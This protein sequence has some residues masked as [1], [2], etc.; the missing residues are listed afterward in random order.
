MP[1]NPIERDLLIVGGGGAAALAALYAAAA[2]VNVTILS[3][4]GFIGG[5]TVQA[6][7]AF[8]LTVDALDSPDIFFQDM[9][10]TGE[11]I[12]NQRLV[13]ALTQNVRRDFL[14]L[15]KWLVRLDRSETYEVRCVKKNG[16]PFLHSLLC[17]QT[18][19]AWYTVCSFIIRESDGR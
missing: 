15:E 5:A 10:H 16:G 8:A 4:T 3:K 12:N 11:G 14:E 19:D 1:M 7:G 9:L 2:G 6:S 18:P 13:K 17:R